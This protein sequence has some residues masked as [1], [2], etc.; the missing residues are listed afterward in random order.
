VLGVE[1]DF[2]WMGQGS[3]SRFSKTIPGAYTNAGEAKSSVDSLATARLRAG[4]AFDRA[5]PY[6]SGGLAFGGTKASSH[7]VG[8]DGFTVDTFS[9]SDSS[10][11]TGWVIG[12]G[13]DYLLA[14]HWSFRLEGMYFDLGTARYAVSPQDAN[15]AAEGLSVSACHKFDGTVFRAALNH[16]F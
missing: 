2:N 10:T 3:S 9:G 7:S 4:Y 8:T 16:S 12:G 6:V 14:N 5:L 1:T 13:V 15:T 11:R